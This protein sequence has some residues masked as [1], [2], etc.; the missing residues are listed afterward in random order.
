M[1]TSTDT[2]ND[3]MSLCGDIKSFGAYYI[4]QHIIISVVVVLC[5]LY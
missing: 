2:D 3:Y 1:E 5:S 4:L